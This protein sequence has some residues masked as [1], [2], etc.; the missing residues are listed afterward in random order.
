MQA[1]TVALSLAVLALVIAVSN[2]QDPASY[3]AVVLT[4][5]PIV[6][7][8][9]FYSPIGLALATAL[10]FYGVSI[11]LIR[12]FQKRKRYFILAL[13]ILLLG[14]SACFF[15]AVRGIKTFAGNFFYSF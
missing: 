6:L 5:V 11:V 2:F 14:H 9:F 8:N 13:C 15:Y 3:A 4:S 1:I 12:L 10:Y 7:L